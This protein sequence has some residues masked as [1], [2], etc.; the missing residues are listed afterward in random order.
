VPRDLTLVAPLETEGA[1]CANCAAQQASP[2][3]AAPNPAAPRPSAPPA[4]IPVPGR[5]RPP[6]SRGADR[7]ITFAGVLIAAVFLGLAGLAAAIRPILGGTPWLP[8]H[9]ALAGAAGT[10]IASVLP[11]FTPALAQA[12]PAR[13]SL[14]IAAVAAVSAGG[15]LAALGMTTGVPAISS[16]GGSV[17]VAGIAAVAAATFLPLRETLGFRFRLVHAAYAVALG[18]VA[19]GVTLAAAM[20]AGWEPVVGAWARLKPTHAWLNLFGFVALVIAASLVHLAPTVAGTRI[21]PRRSGALALRGLMIGAPL[22]A[23]GFATGSDVL[24][25][26]GALIE[27]VGGA[28][29]AIHGLVVWRDRG[30]WTTDPA[31]HRFTSL[32]LLAAPLWLVVAI[33]VAGG[34]V[35]WLGATPAAWSVDQ[36]A[37]PLVVGGIGQILVGSWTHLVPAIGPGD[38]ARHAA[39]RAWLGRAAL[40]RWLAWNL[41]AAAASLGLAVDAQTLVTLGGIAIAAS[42]AG[43]L[44]V[45]LG[46]SVSGRMRGPGS[47]R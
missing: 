20:L 41:G 40:P 5:G 21:R 8:L 37:L 36:L 46:A 15:G 34:R 1:C 13:P 16:T 4:G 30:N 31:W 6:I 12:Q 22:V 19:L 25:R 33:V 27:L 29:L 3:P 39:Q 26:V 9:L 7:R 35:L 38:L 45:L 17:Y 42:L 2:R 18:S 23:A 10:A 47:G 28:S 24:G 43:S 32:S 44:A 11:F 14:R